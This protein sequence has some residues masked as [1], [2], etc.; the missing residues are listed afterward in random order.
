MK[1]DVIMASAKIDT[2]KVNKNDGSTEIVYPV[3]LTKA[4]TDDAGKSL[5]EILDEIG[6]SGLNVTKITQA[7]YDD[8]SEDQQ[9]TGAYLIIDA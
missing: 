6:T 8:L 4:V 9:N 3:T 2:L 5:E 7:E 1:G